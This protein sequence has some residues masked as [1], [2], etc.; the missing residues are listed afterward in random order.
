MFIM[1]PKKLLNIFLLILRYCQ[2]RKAWHET[3]VS[4]TANNMSSCQEANHWAKTHHIWHLLLCLAAQ[5]CWAHICLPCVQQALMMVGSQHLCPANPKPQQAS[6]R[7]ACQA[8]GVARQH[9]IY[10]LKGR[11]LWFGTMRECFTLQGIALCT[12]LFRILAGT[13]L[14]RNIWKSF[15]P[16]AVHRKCQSK[17]FLCKLAQKGGSTE[18]V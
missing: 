13:Q 1:V 5:L 18:S 12:G 6:A 16:I 4:L 9:C 15:S 10:K 14:C 3:R 2:D 7:N 8:E 17:E 11:A